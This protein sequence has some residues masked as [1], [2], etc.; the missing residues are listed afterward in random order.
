M[1]VAMSSTIKMFDNDIHTCMCTTVIH[2]IICFYL[3]LYSTDLPELICVYYRYT[4]V[5]DPK[6][7]GNSR[8]N[9]LQLN[10]LFIQ[11]APASPTPSTHRMRESRSPENALKPRSLHT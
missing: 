9:W 3:A 1:V 7:E 6:G 5:A 4:C 2:V 10:H 8:N 11:E